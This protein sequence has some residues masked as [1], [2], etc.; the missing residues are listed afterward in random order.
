MLPIVLCPLFVCTNLT[1]N[2]RKGRWIDLIDAFDEIMIKN[3]FSFSKTISRLESYKK[4]LRIE[5]Y[6]RNMATHIEYS[7]LGIISKGFRPDREIEKF[8]SQLDLIDRRIERYRYRGRQFNRYL[9][10]VSIKDREL[11]SASFI[12]GIDVEIPQ[13]LIEQT[14][15]EIYEIESAIC[16]REGIDP[17]ESERIELT[18]D[19]DTNLERLC[20][21]F[22]L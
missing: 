6:S 19:V 4:L 2:Q 15:D 8:H 18:E 11:L 17:G 21:F 1:K 13:G 20:D 14:I 12:E 3:Y 9:A 5:F 10:D 7:E 22:A 16:F